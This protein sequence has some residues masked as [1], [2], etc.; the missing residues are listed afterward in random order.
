[1]KSNKKKKIVFL[2]DSLV[3]GGAE[4]ILI[5]II[6]NID[7]NFFNPIL[8]ITRSD[9]D[10]IKELNK[11]I[12]I[13]R[14]KRE[15]KFDFK[16][17]NIFRLFIY[18]QNVDIVYCNSH[19]SYHFLS[20]SFLMRKKTFKTI[21]HSHYGPILNDYKTR[22]LDFILI[23]NVS[24]VICSS[25]LIRE[26]FL[27]KLSFTKKNTSVIINGISFKN[28]NISKKEGTIFNIVQVGRIDSNKSQKTAVNIGILLLKLSVNFKW[29]F[30][31]RFA[32]SKYEKELKEM[33]VENKLEKR[34]IFH[35]ELDNVPNFLKEMDL[36][37]L[38]SKAEGLPIS[39]IEYFAAALPVVS[40]KVG[41]IYELMKGHNA[42]FCV[43]VDDIDNFSS[44]IHKIFTNNEEYKNL[45]LNSVEEMKSQFGI[46]KM[47]EKV[48]NVLN[49]V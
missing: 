1:M 20:F 47:I 40:F 24:H 31:G 27:S 3:I 19:S 46:K 8:C 34:F 30:I 35:G 7:L 22:I 14:L 9:G 38:T 13:L 26:Y 23:R 29:N 6:N 16:A 36:G 21:I 2:T 32:D 48:S 18:N 37:V 4:K 12:E 11:N 33:I 10:L 44:A 42:S 39:I 41:Q 28:I 43:D 15:K 5:N 45:A 17:I 49:L 25:D